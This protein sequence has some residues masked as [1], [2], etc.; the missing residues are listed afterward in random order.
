MKRRDL[1][2]SLTATVLS[3]GSN[4]LWAQN[5]YPNKAVRVVVGVPAGG[6]VDMVARLI[7][8]S[9]GD[10]LGQSFFV[11]NRAGG[12]GII[13]TDFVAKAN[14]DGYTLGVVPAAFIATN[15]SLFKKLPYDPE[16]D[17]API[18]KLVNQTM[19]LVTRP[20]SKVGSLE[21]LVA[22][23]KATPGALTYGS[24]GE[25][26]PH[27]LSGVLFS[28]KAKISLNHVPYKGSAPA[29]VDLL[30][31]HVDIAFAGISE[32]LPHLRSGKLI[33]LGLLAHQRSPL[34]PDVP[35][36]EQKG[37]KG[38]ELSA[39]MCLVAPAG[40]PREIVSR[41]NA[42]VAKALA[43]TAGSKLQEVGLEGSASTPEQL[44]EL[45][46]TESALHR[47]LA[48]AAGIVPQ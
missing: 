21:A 35:T 40:T 32:V 28:N 16:K 31:G 7:S 44:A 17:F 9:L 10:D 43:G 48:K 1:F 13:G 30:A 29:I 20:N 23:A 22:F 24:G 47:E 26:S 11:D 3:T 12:S 14:P 41:L 18:S 4:T 5:P 36:L 33:A 46:R 27:H 37:Y 2:A 19:V 6:S 8:Q 38:V 25:G 42:S 34:L 15:R 45:I 39:W